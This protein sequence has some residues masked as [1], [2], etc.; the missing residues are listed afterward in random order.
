MKFED[1]VQGL[2]WKALMSSFN[3][4]LEEAFKGKDFTKFTWVTP[5]A[6]NNCEVCKHMNGVTV[7]SDMVAEIYPA[8]N[9]CACFL[10]P[11]I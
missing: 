4:G 2:V 9:R 8:H 10:I 1:R 5:R 11:K 7:T 3:M 6:D